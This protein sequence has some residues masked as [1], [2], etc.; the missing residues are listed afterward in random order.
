MTR[1]DR[2]RNAARNALLKAGL[3]FVVALASACN[4]ALGYQAESWL[5]LVVA[6]VVAVLSA[7]LAVHF[8]EV[9]AANY[10]RAEDEW[11]WEM[12]HQNVQVKP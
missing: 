3:S 7:V 6:L 5:W 10:R 1:A 4:I 8:F 12:R 9:M 2:Y 11:L